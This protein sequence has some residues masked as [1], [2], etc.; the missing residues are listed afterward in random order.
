MDFPLCPMS[1][2]INNGS[3][4]KT[5]PINLIVIVKL[6]VHKKYIRGATTT[7]VSMSRIHGILNCLLSL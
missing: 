6:I 2:I 4:I 5:V 1:K 7:A 3:P